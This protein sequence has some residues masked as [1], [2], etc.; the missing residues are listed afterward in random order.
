MSTP[1]LTICTLFFVALGLASVSRAT[2]SKPEPTYAEMATSAVS[3]LQGTVTVTKAVPA[4]L[5]KINR[6]LNLTIVMITHQMEV[7]KQ[8]CDRVGILHPVL[9]QFWMSY[10]V[11]PGETPDAPLVGCVAVEN[12]GDVALLRMLAVAPE[13]RGEGLGF[14]LVEA[15]PPT[16]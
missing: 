4:E 10:L 1:K 6:E 5:R 7:I 14:V 16:M 3:D 15:P 12:V 2:R 11:I 9:D 8:V 13:R